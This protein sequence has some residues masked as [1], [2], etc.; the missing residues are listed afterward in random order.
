MTKKELVE[1]LN[2]NFKDDEEVF[3]KY[4]DDQGTCIDGIKKIEDIT[5]NFIEHHFEIFKDG[6]WSK[7]GN[8]HIQFPSWGEWRDV[9]DR[10]WSETK[11]CIIVN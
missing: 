7:W 1:L 11:K 10:K 9:I 3:V 4:E 6:K 2:K 8:K 5:Q